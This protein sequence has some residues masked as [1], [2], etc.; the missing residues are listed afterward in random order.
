MEN[1]LKIPKIKSSPIQSSIFIVLTA[2]SLHATFV[3]LSVACFF[4]TSGYITYF[5]ISIMVK[6]GTSTSNEHKLL[7]NIIGVVFLFL[8][9]S[10]LCLY[11]WYYLSLNKVKILDY[12]S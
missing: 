4:T 9:L 7:H 3:P 2:I 11:I 5:F 12:L 10:F 1:T 8:I 6:I